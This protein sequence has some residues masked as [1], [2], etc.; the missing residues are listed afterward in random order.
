MAPPAHAT[1][2]GPGQERTRG[3]G[4]GDVEQEAV[5]DPSCPPHTFPFELSLP[6]HKH[7]AL[8]SWTPGLTSSSRRAFPWD[9][10]RCPPHSPTWTAPALPP[11][12]TAA[13]TPLCSA[14]CPEKTVLPFL[15][16]NLLFSDPTNSPVQEELS[17]LVSGNPSRWFSSSRKGT[18]RLGGEESTQTRYTG[19]ASRS[20]KDCWTHEPPRMQHSRILCSRPDPGG[21]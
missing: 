11:E 19:R 6:H 14:H 20:S 8:P 2:G 18:D 13:L 5:A 9:P 17:H 12:P 21:D 4:V 10:C 3:P 7:G 1:L 16:R 15:Q